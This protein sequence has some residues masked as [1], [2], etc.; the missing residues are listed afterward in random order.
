MGFYPVA[1]GTDE[2]ALG[3]PLFKKITL[4]L[5]NGKKMVINA[6]DNNQANRYIGSMKVN[7]KEYDKNYITYPML[8]EGGEI[9]LEMTDKPNMERG[10]SAEA[11]PYSFSTDASNPV[12]AKK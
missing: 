9:D 4:N 11:A 8:M 7:G 2:Y 10:T 12:N 5:E 6:S 3:S 1:P